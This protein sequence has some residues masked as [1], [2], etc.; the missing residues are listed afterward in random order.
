M[1]MVRT[2]K[3][4]RSK[5]FVFFVMMIVTVS[6][7]TARADIPLGPPIQV[8]DEDWTIRINNEDDGADPRKIIIDP[9]SKDAIILATVHIGLYTNW[10]ILRITSEGTLVWSTV[11]GSNSEISYAGLCLSPDG[12]V[13]YTL[14]EGISAESLMVMVPEIYLASFEADNGQYV[15][16]F[17]LDNPGYELRTGANPDLLFH[18]DDPDRL[19]INYHYYNPVNYDRFAQVMEID[20]SSETP[21]WYYEYPVNARDPIP[22]GIYYSPTT[23]HVYCTINY[24][25]SGNSFYHGLLW[26][27]EP[28]AYGLR[29][30]V[31]A[32]IGTNTNYSTLAFTGLGS[33]VMMIIGGEDNFD[34]EQGEYIPGQPS[35]VQ[36]FDG[37]LNVIYQYRLAWNYFNN[38]G[39]KDA[40]LWDGGVKMSILGTVKYASVFPEWPEDQDGHLAFIATYRI[41]HVNGY[42]K[43][44][45]VHYH[46]LTQYYVR[47]ED[48]AFLEGFGYY[49]TGFTEIFSETKNEA[50]GFLAKYSMLAE[51]TPLEPVG[52]SIFEEIG[53][54]FQ[55][56]WLTL[57]TGGGVG[58]VSGG[59]L[60]GLLR[61]KK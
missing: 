1:N 21:T 22:G 4:K 23:D 42:L 55:N 57:S 18:P 46:G 48:T 7:T 56:N 51:K 5:L 38:L 10:S 33:Q 40:Y 19:F 49:L 50:N 36:F 31:D 53:E 47:V 32:K 20:M 43:L 13:L 52:S 14:T 8:N 12:D 44:I 41:D 34:Y 6:L 29:I 24:L 28:T 27:I 59:L 2:T 16:K 58:L 26:K 9:V 35:Y 37:N 60:V 17:P 11:L 25:D 54:F 30:A 15:T 3:L 45:N 39:I 61:R